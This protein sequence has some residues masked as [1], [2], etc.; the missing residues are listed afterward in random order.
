MSFLLFL[1]GLLGLGYIILILIFFFKLPPKSIEKKNAKTEQKSVSVII[2]FRNEAENLKLLFDTLVKQTYS[3][4]LIKIYFIND[5]STDNSKEILENLAFQ[6]GEFNIEIIDLEEERK[7]K[8]AALQK[9]YQFVNSEIILSTDADCL[10]PEQWINISVQAFEEEDVQMLCGGIKIQSGK[11]WLEQFQSVEL[12][13]LMGSGAA[14]IQ[15]NQPIMS[16]GANLAFR[17]SVLQEIDFSKIKTDKAS[18]DD[19]FLMIEI[20]RKMG[21]HAIRFEFDPAHWVYTKAMVT[22]EQLVQQRIR[23]TSKTKNYNNPFQIFV[24]LIVLLSN[25][26]IPVLFIWSLFSLKITT[27]LL[28][29]WLIK[30]IIDFIFIKKVAEISNQPF[31]FPMYMNTAIIY[32][33]FISY[34]AII[35]QFANFN[36]KGRNYQSK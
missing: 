20:F 14:S 4:E 29:Y 9:A 10:L 13:S 22:F 36:W 25:L 12:M 18:G 17:K 35:G 32:P 31:T 19:V 21:S 34:I 16:N 2:P 15:I 11:S 24:S 5:H 8:K 26:G 27:S 23:W 33:F 1:I 6:N 7:G 28:I 30:L 3:R